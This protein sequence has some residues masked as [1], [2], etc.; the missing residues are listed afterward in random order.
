[1]DEIVIE[2]P[3]ALLKG[4]HNCRWHEKDTHRC[5]DGDP[6][7]CNWENDGTFE[8]FLTKGDQND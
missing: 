7:D 2:I 4:C 1:M 3:E 5:N 6:Y 8:E